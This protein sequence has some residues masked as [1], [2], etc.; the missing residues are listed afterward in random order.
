MSLEDLGQ[1][2]N[3]NI[4]DKKYTYCVIGNK[5]KMDIEF[6]K[7]LGDYKELTLEEIFGY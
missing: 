1:F 2:F 7:S 3:Q 5:E 6:L 4:K